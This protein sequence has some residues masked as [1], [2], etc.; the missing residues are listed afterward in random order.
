[1]AGNSRFV[2]TNYATLTTT[3]L[4]TGTG[5][6]APA[7]DETAGAIMENAI[8]ADRGTFWKTSSTPAGTIDFDIDLGAALASGATCA[9]L[10]GYRPVGAGTFATCVVKSS[11]TVTYPRTWTTRGTI[12]PPTWVDGAANM[13][14]MVVTFAAVTDRFWRWEF[15]TVTGTGF[16]MGQM[17]LGTMTDLGMY[18]AAN[19]EDSPVRYRSRARTIAGHPVIRDLGDEGSSIVLLFPTLHQV[20]DAAGLTALLALADKRGSFFYI[21]PDDRLREVVLS[22][23]K[24]TRTRVF[25][26]V[27]GL[28]VE[29]EQVP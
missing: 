4:T 20:N 15:T 17:L 24:V 2:G 8:Y 1:M 29:L 26:N 18:Y 22:Q 5:G 21:S 28:Q 6:S 19:S 23:D 3:S 27:D 12:T 13:R 25:N 7:D 10:C 16:S 14:D 9:G 11:T